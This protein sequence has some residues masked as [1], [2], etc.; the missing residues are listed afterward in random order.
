MHPVAKRMP[1]VYRGNCVVSDDEYDDDSD[2]EQQYRPSPTKHASDMKHDEDLR[3]AIDQILSTMPVSS[4][5]T[6]DSNSG[7]MNAMMPNSGVQNSAMSI[8]SQR[9]EEKSFSFYSADRD[10]MDQIGSF[11]GRKNSV[12]DMEDIQNLRRRMSPSVCPIEVSIEAWA[13]A[14]FMPR[15]P[16]LV[17]I[18][19]SR[20]P[21]CMS[22]TPRKTSSVEELVI[23]SAENSSEDLNSIEEEEEVNNNNEQ[24]SP[25]IHCKIPAPVVKA[26]VETSD[27]K[28]KTII[29]KPS[30]RRPEFWIG[31]KDKAFL[32]SACLLML[33][34]YSVQM[35]LK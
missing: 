22:S 11:K 28:K 9:D 16:E 18:D 29:D 4:R 32:A 8:S 15:I 20:E 31:I 10:D 2:E 12:K 24:S 23:R 17:Q 26:V 14:G 1:I 30:L 6:R 21:K 13:C 27:R 19:F 34:A 7:S 35:S 25:K 33:A 5:R 3:D